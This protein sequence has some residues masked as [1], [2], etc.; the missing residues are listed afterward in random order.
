MRPKLEILEQEL[1]DRIVAEAHELLWDPGV[2]VYRE[3]A[4]RLLAEGGATVDFEKKIARIPQDMIEE[5]LKT[6]P[7]SVD[8]Y[9]LKGELRLHLGGDN[10]YFYPGATALQIIDPVTDEYRPPVTEDLVRF[11]QVVEGLPQLD[12]QAG[13]L[14]CA[15]VPKMVSDSYR[16]YLMLLYGTKPLCGG[17]FSIEGWYS[18]KDLLVAYFGSEEAIATKPV[19]T[20]AICPSPP[21][22][23]SEIT[24]QNLMDCARWGLPAVLISMPLAGATAPVTIAGAVTQ[25]A[26][27][28]LSGV[29]IHQLVNPGAPI[30]YGS[31]PAMFDMR[32]GTTPMGSI[33]TVMINC[34]NAQVGKYLG[35]PTH[36]YV[37]LSDAKIV[38]AQ[39]GLES[40]MGAILGAL[41][42]INLICGAG[43]SDFESGLSFEKV[44]VDAEVIGMVKRLLAGVEAHEESLATALMRE[45]GHHGHFLA[46]EHTRKWFREEQYIPSAVIDRASQSIWENRGAKNI[47]QRARERAQA[48]IAQ[49]Q[50]PDVPAEV[51]KE[52][53]AVMT[54]AAKR[55][56][57]EELPSLPES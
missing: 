47:V 26:A 18:M 25:H 10:V 21:L 17:A 32:E 1:V 41:A 43:M 12:A 37:G 19:N 14:L 5:A 22:L 7:G 33:E 50:P 9:D 23:W 38:D 6:A 57:M 11:I 54:R 56:G 45:V 35:L 13:S 34:A 20:M 2:R 3:G 31:S 8:I 53:K 44:V 30:I 52:L 46:T 29:V 15:D 49:Y 51:R 39:A 40:A 48:L 16:Y 28:S 55:Y 42:G 36:G 24:C 27:E 4:L